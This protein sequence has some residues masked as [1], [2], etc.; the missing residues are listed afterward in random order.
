[1]R[2]NKRNNKLKMTAVIAVMLVC[3]LAIGGTIAYLT[4]HSKLANTFTVGEIAPID[5]D[6]SGPDGNENIDKDE[7]KLQG[8]LYEPNW[9]SDSKLFPTAVIPKDPYVGVGKGSESCV[10]Y[11]YVTNEMENNNHIY[12]EKQAGWEPVEGCVEEV[13]VDDKTYYKGGLFEYTEG[14]DGT[15]AKG[16]VWTKKP[17]FEN[18]LISDK[19]DADDFKVK[20]G[21]ATGG[22]PTIT[23]QSYLHQK[24]NADQGDIDKETI[25]KAAKEKF[26]IK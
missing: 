16:N 13:T 19:A 10:V 4:S 25:E 18:V 3:I 24:Q 15:E 1:M 6:G 22:K 9:K 12:F 20:E 2:E 7:T 5:P 17:L 14:L 26:G 8:N 23:V 21:S 11:V